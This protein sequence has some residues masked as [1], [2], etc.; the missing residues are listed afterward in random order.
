[1]SR[2]KKHTFLGQEFDFSEK[3]K[4]KIKQTLH[5]EDM[6]ASCPVQIKKDAVAT[7]P[8]G[9]NLL[10]RGDST[11]LSDKGREAFHT[12][13][14]KGIFMGK[15]SRPDIQPTISVLSGRVRQPTKQ[16]LEKLVRLCK[17]LQC[18]KDLHLILSIDDMKIIKWYI[19][20]SYAV[21]ED[22]RSHSGLVTKFGQGSAIS[23]SL[24]QKINTRSSTEAELV[25]VDDFMGMILWT[26]HFL[27]AQGYGIFKHILFQDNNSAILLEKNGK[28]SAGKRS[29]HLNV[30][31]FFVKDIVDQGRLTIQHCPTL[32]MPADFM[33]KPLQGSKFLEFRNL[34]L[35]M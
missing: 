10:Q 9:N 34:I 6:I 33:T 13:V 20:A 30:R 29:R 7:T 21:H 35:G 11:L 5:V 23:A 1:M 18:T 3:G 4:V 2:G 32:D 28:A 8:A 19:D 16:D 24:K 31:Y 25:G 22:F 12:C 15:R 26:Q 14:A 17:Y 27:E